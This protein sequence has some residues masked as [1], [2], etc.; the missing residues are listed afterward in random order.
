MEGGVRGPASGVCK[1]HQN[2]S[3]GD[4]KVGLAALPNPETFAKMQ[5]GPPAERCVR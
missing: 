2:I 3:F 1:P 5:V 4:D